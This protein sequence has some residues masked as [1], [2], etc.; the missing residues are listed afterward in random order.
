MRLRKNFRSFFCVLIGLSL[1][2]A[3][4]ALTLEEALSESLQ[5]SKQIAASKQA[6]LAAREAVFSSSNSNEHS[7]TYSGSGSYSKTNSGSGWKAS[8]TYSNKITLSKNIYDF[9]KTREKTKLAEI[10][11]NS[12]YAGYKNTEQDVLLKT[13]KAYLDLIKTRREHKLNQNNLA[14]LAKHVAAAELQVSE[15]TGTPTR[16]AEARARY[17]KA[18]SDMVRSSANLNNAEDLFIKLTDMDKLKISKIQDLPKLT[19]NLP[20]SIDETS[21]KAR[22]KSPKV[23]T[24]LAAERVASQNIETF[25]AQQKPGITFSLSATEGEK[26]DSWAASLSLSSSLYDSSTTVADARKTVASHAKAKFDLEEARLN[27]EVEAR[28]AFRNWKAALSS[29]AAVR[30]ETEASRLASNGVRNEVKFG[31]KTTLDLL[32][33]EKNVSDADLRLISAEHDRL[34]A[35]FT[36]SAAVG[37]LT[38]EELGLADPT[39]A[40]SDLPRPENPLE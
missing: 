6:W 28:A 7:L 24:A 30:S 1:T 21:A 33:S 9:G 34:V 16:V 36:L 13:T 14:R 29:L 39:V 31:L 18:K 11:L 3:V 40:F 2:N 38:I 17:L 4:H 8:D 12:A 26:S 25:K 23:L 20:S 19:Q 5:N 27:A 22:E 32:D 10:Q 15:G 37:T 35:A